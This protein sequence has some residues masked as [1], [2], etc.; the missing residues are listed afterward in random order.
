MSESERSTA[1]DRMLS[2]F[3]SAKALGKEADVAVADARRALENEKRNSFVVQEVLGQ[4]K[5][6]LIDM[7]L[8]YACA[9]DVYCL[10]FVRAFSPCRCA[11]RHTSERGKGWFQR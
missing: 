5:V 9:S 3:E 1:R 4:L 6:G 10:M 8:S 2:I 7:W 11:R